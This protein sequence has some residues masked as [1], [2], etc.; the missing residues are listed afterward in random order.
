MNIGFTGTRK[1]LTDYQKAHLESLFWVWSRLEAAEIKLHHGGCVGADEQA[2]Y[3]AIKYGMTSVCHWPT[4]RKFVAL[5]TPHEHREAQP[6]LIRN[7]NIVDESDFLLAC[8]KQMVEIR[9]SGTWA[10]VRYA[11]RVNKQLMVIPPE[12]DLSGATP[13]FDRPQGGNLES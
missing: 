4:D 1:G 10:T 13:T 6:Y 12:V 7:H 11:R 8:P 9:R 2:H 5:I 3:L